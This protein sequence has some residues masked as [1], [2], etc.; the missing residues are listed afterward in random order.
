MGPTRASL[1]PPSPGRLTRTSWWRTISGSSK[2]RWVAWLTSLSLS[3]TLYFLQVVA[4][5]EFSPTLVNCH[6]LKDYFT[7]EMAEQF[8]T[9]VLA[10]QKENNYNVYH[11]TH[12]KRFLHSPWVARSF[13]EKYPD[14]KVTTVRH[15]SDLT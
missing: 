5:Q 15:H 4:A 12:R 13:V 6:A 11:E 14:M 2:S 3:L 10:W 1:P 7:A 8:F 9:D